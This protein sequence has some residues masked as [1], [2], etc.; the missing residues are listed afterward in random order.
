MAAEQYKAV[1]ILQLN[2][3]IDAVNAI[4]SRVKDKGYYPAWCMEQ[5]RII[6]A[7]FPKELS[8]SSQFLFPF[9]WIGVFLILICKETICLCLQ[10]SP[11]LVFQ[12]LF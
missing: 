1:R 12:S 3:A 5:D 11:L 7:I 8:F 10:Q 6:T 2:N 4:C 9:F